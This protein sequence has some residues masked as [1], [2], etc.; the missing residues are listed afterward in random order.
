MKPL[1][2][3]L[4][5]LMN[6]FWASTYSV[7]KTLSPVLDANGLATL[8]YGLAAVILFLF[9]Y[10]LPGGAPRGRDLA[11]AIVMGVIAFGF[12]PRLQVAGVQMGRAGDASVL[13]A[14]DPIIVSICAAVFLRERVGLRRWA[15]FAASMAGAAMVADVWRPGFRLPMLTAD[16]LIV[17]SLFCDAASSIMGKG[18]VQRNGLLKCLAVAV[19]AG[20]ATN[21]L[22]GGASSLRTVNVLSLRD[23]SLVVYL[24]IICTVA[25]YLL[26]FAVIRE[27][28]VNTAA[29]TIFV[30]P[31]AGMA[32]AMVL[33]GESLHWGQIIG[34]TVIGAALVVELVGPTQTAAAE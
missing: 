31:V 12:S 5:V 21:F 8:R 10:W 15:G 19:A 16:I 11:G 32:I 17:L 7:F 34:G 13:I 14:L 2:L 26:W 22:M 1:H 33:L 3:F 27:T 6:V 28:Q 25:G 24:A 23:W 4:L 18:I 29:L 20:A 30:Q 9:W